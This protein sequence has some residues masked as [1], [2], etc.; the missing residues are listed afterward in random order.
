MA[1]TASAT[2]VIQVLS[3]VNYEDQYIVSL[4]S[5]NPLPKLAQGSIRVKT[6]VLSLTAN[7]LM[8]GRIGYILEMWPIHPLPTLIPTH[9]SDPEQFSHID[10]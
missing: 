1:A 6:S 9:Y 3:R 5:A 4:L 10:T 8:Y 2:P 7:T